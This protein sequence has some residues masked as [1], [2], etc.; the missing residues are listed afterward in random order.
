MFIEN[1]GC[2]F[3]YRLKTCSGPRRNHR[4]IG[5]LWCIFTARNSP[6]LSMEFLGVTLLT[7][8]KMLVSTFVGVLFTQSGFDKLFDYAANLQYL[9]EYF[10][11]SILAGTA[12]LLLPTITLLELSAGLLS[13][14]GVV[15]LFITGSELVAFYGLLL[16]AISIIGLFAGQRLTKDYPGAAGIVPYFIL[17]SF[18]IYLYISRI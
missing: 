11:N 14:L 7:V 15:M 5:R 12:E 10:K 4:Q 3:P 6:L 13:L 8:L 2:V 9:R 16:G 18:G 1:G 17:I